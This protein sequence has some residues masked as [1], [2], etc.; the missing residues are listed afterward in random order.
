MIFQTQNQVNS[1]FIFIFFG[2]II[3]VLSILFFTFFIENFQKKPIKYAINT[4][5]YAFFCCFF[6]FLLNLFNFGKFSTTLIFAYT[7][8]FI[9]T[10]HSTQKLVVILQKK[11]YTIVNKIFSK[12]KKKF[13]KGKI[14]TNETKKES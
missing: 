6:V 9:L 1:L 5:F 11:W 12:I 14:Q 2:F 7:I 10:K 8:S 3:G 13:K 4:L